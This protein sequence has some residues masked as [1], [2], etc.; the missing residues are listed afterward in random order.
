MTLK[1]TYGPKNLRHTGLGPYVGA[2]MV[3][4]V[5]RTPIDSVDH[6]MVEHDPLLDISQHRLHLF[7][8]IRDISKIA[9]RYI[10]LDIF[11]ISYI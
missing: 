8:Y 4:P 5:C 6:C 7:Y 9:F 2:R 1:T 3:G 11:K 10:K